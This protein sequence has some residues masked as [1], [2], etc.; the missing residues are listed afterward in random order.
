MKTVTTYPH[1]VIFYWKYLCVKNH[2]TQGGTN[3]TN[4]YYRYTSFPNCVHFQLYL[5]WR[6][7]NFRKLKNLLGEKKKIAITFSY[8]RLSYPNFACRVGLKYFL[9]DIIYSCCLPVFEKTQL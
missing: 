7:V 9:Y 2:C 4:I 3:P 1:G 5:F 8:C 6:K